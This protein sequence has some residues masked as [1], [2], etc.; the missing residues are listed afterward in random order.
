MSTPSFP[1][2]ADGCC[3]GNL[4]AWKTSSQAR[5]NGTNRNRTN[6]TNQLRRQDPLPHRHLLAPSTDPAAS[7][8][9]PQPHVL[10]RPSTTAHL[11]SHRA[12]AQSVHVRNALVRLQLKSISTEVSDATKPVPS[13]NQPITCDWPLKPVFRP[14]CS[15]MPLPAVT[16]GACDPTRRR[17]CNGYAALLTARSLRSPMTRT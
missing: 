1:C 15:S 16:A 12:I 8:I 9:H 6:L 2:H 14:P 5:S 7:L 4:Y 17:V 10:L 11:P 3:N 13:M